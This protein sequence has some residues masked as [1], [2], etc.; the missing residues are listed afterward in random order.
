MNESQQILI[1]ED[2][3]D[4][5]EGVSYR[6]RAAGFSPLSAG[7]STSGVEIAR[8][9]RPDLILLDVQLPDKDG[10][11]TL[12]ELRDDEMTSQIPVI[13]L[14]AS[15]TE[16]VRALDAGARF[17]L[18]KPYEGKCLLSAVHAVLSPVC[19]A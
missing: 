17:F 12:R 11:T 9:N 13:M 4:I 16:E 3:H 1:I 15:L 2:E 18:Q 8:R 7:D 5:C 6:L 10:I 14:S 19:M